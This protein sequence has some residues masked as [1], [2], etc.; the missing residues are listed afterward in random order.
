MALHGNNLFSFGTLLKAFRIRRR[1]TQQQLA[2]KLDVR[3]NTIGAWERGDFSLSRKL[4]S[5]NSSDTYAWMTRRL[6]P[7]W[8][9]A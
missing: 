9:P 7:S 6:V 1:L 4:S 8:K 3:R 2:A 5:S